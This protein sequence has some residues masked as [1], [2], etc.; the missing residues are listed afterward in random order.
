MQLLGLDLTQ[1]HIATSFDAKF[2]I[3]AQGEPKSLT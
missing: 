2:G 1:L 3:I